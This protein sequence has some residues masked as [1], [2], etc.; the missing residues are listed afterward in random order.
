[1]D[2]TH[3][4][5]FKD[6]LLLYNQISEACFKRCMNTFISREISTDEDICLRKCLEKHI[7]ANHKMMEIFMEVQPVLVQRRIE[8]VQSAQAALEATQSQVEES[9]SQTT[10]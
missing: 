3:M 8:E 10:A 7:H 4:R 1:M 9:V 5:N 6:F 2:V